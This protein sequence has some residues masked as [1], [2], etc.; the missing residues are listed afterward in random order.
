M[1]QTER[2]F[3]G[4]R[5]VEFG[6]YVAVPYAAELFAHGGADVVKVE[7]IGGDNT[8]HNTPIVPMEGRQY[9]IK[10]RGKRAIA[11]DLRAP[12][13]LAAARQLIAQSDI[14]LSNMRPGA[15]ERLGLGYD[16]VAQDHPGVIYGEISAFGTTGPEANKPGI[17]PVVQ[18]G[19]GLVAA[20]RGTEDGRPVF[21]EAF[22]ADYMAGT[23]LAFGVVS[24]LRLRDRT[25]RGQHITTSLLQASLAVM[26]GQA[27]IFH[28]VD[29]WK[30]DFVQWLQEEHP[31]FEEAAT[32]RRTHLAT[33]HWWLN[34]YETSDGVIAIGAPGPLRKPLV[35]VT[36]VQDPAVTDPNWTMPDDPRPY[37]DALT[38]QARTVMRT[39]KTDE[40][41]ARLE[42]AG[43]PCSRVQFMEEVLLGEHARANGYVST[44][45]H[46][47][48]G[49]ITMPTPPVQFS[50]SQYE[51]GESSPAYGEHTAQV[52]TDLGFT[53][54]EIEALR[55]SGVAV[56]G[57]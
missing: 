42:E 51:A 15:L 45:D 7:P 5:V 57:D 50:D 27:N 14:V 22:V 52:L 37:I 47:R 33:G 30:L 39:W 2:L 24:A 10:A 25:G 23:L 12:E 3:E 29:Q 32:R 11:L 16:D 46:P 34:T 31:P 8:R 56:L 19:A 17:D 1:D 9:I 54:E 41:I 20:G 38:E 28:V 40:L 55:D 44:F 13:G 21:N 26:H 49:P 53:S 4:V 43:I 18:A 6:Q 35:A 36:G 48:V